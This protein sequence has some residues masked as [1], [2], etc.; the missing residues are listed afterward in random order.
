MFAPRNNHDDEGA[1]AV[2]FAL[3]SVVLILFLVGIVQFGY[4]FFQYLEVVHSA[5][6]GARWAALGVEAGSVSDPTSVRGRV[7]SAA[8]GLSPG[9]VDANITVS[10]AGGGSQAV[11]PADSGKPVTVGVSYSSPIFMPLLG[12]IVGGGAF[13]LKSSATLRVE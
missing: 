12:D 9:L 2:E 13:A 1:S 4:T 3:V 8:P 10:V 6:E 5:R 11:I 7:A